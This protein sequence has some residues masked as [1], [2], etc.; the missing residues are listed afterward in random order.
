MRRE[1]SPKVRAAAFARAAGLC[2]ICTAKLYTGKYHFD[3]RI[4]DALGGE[5]SLAN[6]V[7]VCVACHSAKTVQE[8]VPRISKAKRT[9]LKHIG[10]DKPSYRWPTRR[11]G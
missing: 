1:F 5:P 4:P 11:F 9:H 8:D 3:H 2:Q 6:C 7:V 10:A